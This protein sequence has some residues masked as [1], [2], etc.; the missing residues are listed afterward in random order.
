LGI[1]PR[2]AGRARDALTHQ[3]EA[4]NSGFEWFFGWLQSFCLYWK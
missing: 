3:G 1:A 2:V 4:V